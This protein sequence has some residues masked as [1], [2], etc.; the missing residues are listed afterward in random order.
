MFDLSRGGARIA[1][2]PDISAAAEV[3]VTLDRMRPLKAKVAWMAGGCFGVRFE[4]AMLDAGELLSL[5]KVDAA[6]A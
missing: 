5:I 2:V 4:P 3:T 6:A 1:A